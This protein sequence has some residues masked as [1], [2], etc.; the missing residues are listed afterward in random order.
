MVTFEAYPLGDP[1]G[2]ERS[3][4]FAKLPQLLC[5]CLFYCR[6]SP[7]GACAKLFRLTQE[8]LVLG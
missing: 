7:R 5:P 3:R 4:Q 2:R 8:E 6:L 1:E